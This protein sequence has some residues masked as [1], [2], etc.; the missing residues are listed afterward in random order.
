MD[1]RDASANEPARSHTAHVMR[2]IGVG[3]VSGRYSQNSILPGDA[4]LMERFKVSRTVL[5]EAMKTLA[6][7]GLIQA[8][9][10]IG[11]RV[12][13]RSDWNLFDRDVLLW[14]AEVGFDPDF[15]E[16]LNEMRMA[17]E[18]EAAA[19]AAQR[20]SP[21]QLDVLYGWVERMAAEPD[22]PNS[23]V[24]ADLNFHLAVST[25]AGNPFFRSIA[26]LIEV[27]LVALLTISSPAE[28]RAR[29]TQSVADH[30][31]IADAIARRD[32]EEARTAM[33]AVIQI[34]LD[35]ARGP[36]RKR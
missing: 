29:L 8:K 6:G 3:I 17:L 27:A 15:V 35:M 31:A 22:R 20:R 11:T 14:H 13:D 26:T 36:K 32:P 25:A 19:L 5:R 7:K 28:D 2:E 18:P 33:R 1:F 24:I 12:R 16:H 9:A 10:R 30:R 23:F 21:E 34:G 4:E